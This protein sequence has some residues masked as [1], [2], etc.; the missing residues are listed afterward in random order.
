[1]ATVKALR[2]SGLTMVMIRVGPSRRSLIPSMRLLSAK[3]I[4]LQVGE[5][6][7]GVFDEELAR[8]IRRQ[9]AHPLAELA[10]GIAAALEMRVVGAEDIRFFHAVALDHQRQVLVPEGRHAD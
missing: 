4:S 2:R 3:E 9:L 10:I 6:K 1:M 5:E 7:A 8:I